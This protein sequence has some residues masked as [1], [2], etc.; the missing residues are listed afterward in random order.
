MDDAFQS[1]D[2]KGIL[3]RLEEADANLRDAIYSDLENFGYVHIPNVVKEPDVA[4]IVASFRKWQADTPQLQ[5]LHPSI[6]P[7]GMYK[8][9]VGQQRHAWLTRTNPGVLDIFRLLYGKD[10]VSS[11]DGSCYIPGAGP[12]KR[13]TCW[14]HTDQAPLT[15]GLQCLQG[16]VS[17]TRN[18]ECTFTLYRG[19]HLLHEPY[20][21]DRVA[22]SPNDPKWKKNFVFIDPDYLKTIQHTY[23]RVAVGPGDLILWDSR[24]F[25][26][27][28][29]GTKPEE[30]IVQ[31]VAF[32]PRGDPRNTAA[33]RKKR[34]QYFDEGRTTSHRPF[35]LSVNGMQ[36]QTYGDSS[37][38]IDYSALP[39]PDL[40]DLLPK[41]R[42]LL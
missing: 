21:K 37:K 41:I 6:S 12:R 10:L 18:E 35:P 1:Y 30:R 8:F 13:E 7:H 26:Q 36:P 39:P 40:A 23:T 42:A 31:Y 27:N 2:L 24:L 3:R 20:F 17:M 28:A 22:E 38:L 14:T 5:K 29:Y 33:M 19:S 9:A 16:L 25:H 32:M 15:K 34:K 11:M 4:E